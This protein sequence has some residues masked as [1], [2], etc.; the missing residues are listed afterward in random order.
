MIL[1]NLEYLLFILL[2]S[3]HF[4]NESAEW[5]EAPDFVF[6]VK[7]F[8][9]FLTTFFIL[10]KPLRL[11]KKTGYDFTGSLKYLVSVSLL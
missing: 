9:P 7:S 3:F 8:S 2:N 5:N 4:L 11:N 6:S 1:L 10:F